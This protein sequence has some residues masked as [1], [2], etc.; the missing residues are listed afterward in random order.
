MC[1]RYAGRQTY[2]RPPAANHTAADD[3]DYTVTIYDSFTGGKLK[4]PLYATAGF[5]NHTGF[6]TIEL[7]KPVIFPEGEDFYIC[8]ELSEGG[9]PIDRTTFVPVLLGG[10]EN[11]VANGKNAAKKG[12][13]TADDGAL[14]E[15]SSNPGESYYLNGTVWEDLY[16][17]NNT[18]NFCI[19]GLA[20]VLPPQHSVH[21][22]KARR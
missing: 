9:Q 6:H 15:S 11:A 8:L 17:W 18:S 16:Y 20:T 3:V 5:I 14:V 21:P 10:G 1:H 12:G 22:C 2:D 7:D 4:R 19:K 13:N